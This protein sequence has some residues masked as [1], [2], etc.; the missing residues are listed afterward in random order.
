MAPEGIKLWV[1]LLGAPMLSLSRVAAD[2]GGVIA[3]SK[4]VGL[5]GLGVLGVL[6]LGGIIGLYLVAEG[7]EPPQRSIEDVIPDDKFPS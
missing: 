5:I 2:E 4:V 6:I 3:L 1:K 7:M